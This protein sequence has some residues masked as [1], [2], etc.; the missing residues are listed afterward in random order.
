MRGRG[1]LLQVM[2][3]DVAVTPGESQGARLAACKWALLHHVGTTMSASQDSSKRPHEITN[4]LWTCD[5]CRT[6]VTIHSSAAVGEVRCP[7]CSISWM[8]PC[9]TFEDVLGLPDTQKPV[10]WWC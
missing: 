4:S 8:T 6:F 2:N 5:Q 7:V 3:R 1:S 10:A 9:G